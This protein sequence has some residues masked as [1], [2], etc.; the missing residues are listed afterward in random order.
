[1]RM[2]IPVCLIVVE[3]RTESI[4]ARLRRGGYDVKDTI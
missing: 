1:M 3:R 4:A 2:I